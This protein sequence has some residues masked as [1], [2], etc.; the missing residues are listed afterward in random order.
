M[1]VTVCVSVG[2]GDVCDGV[3]VSVGI[4]LYMHPKTNEFAKEGTHRKHIWQV[5]MGTLHL[6]T[7]STYCVRVCVCVCVCVCV[8]VCVY[9][10]VCVRD[11]FNQYKQVH[12]SV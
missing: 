10:C 8:Y 1:C 9:V 3:C 4:Y 5:Y 11:A 6:C 2:Q 12:V 7:C